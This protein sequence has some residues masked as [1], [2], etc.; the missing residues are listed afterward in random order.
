MTLKQ[1]AATYYSKFL[2]EQE[3]AHSIKNHTERFKAELALMSIF[4]ECY[5]AGMKDKLV[6]AVK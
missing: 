6:E 1:K 2:E 4:E 3:K 5:K